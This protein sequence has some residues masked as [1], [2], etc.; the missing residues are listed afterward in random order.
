MKNNRYIYVE[1]KNDG[2]QMTWNSWLIRNKSAITIS[3]LIKLISTNNIIQQTYFV[4][5]KL[6]FVTHGIY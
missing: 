6:D 2:I 5:I 3:I 4:D 1:I